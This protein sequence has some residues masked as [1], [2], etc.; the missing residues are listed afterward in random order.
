M[1]REPF[2]DEAVD[3][4]LKA[5]L[6]R[7]RFRTRDRLERPM[8]LVDR[9][10]LDPAFDDGALRGGEGRLVGVRRRHDLVLVRTNNALPELRGLNVA[11]HDRAHALAIGV[12]RLGFVEAEPGLPVRGVGAVARE[13]ILGENRADLLVEGNLGVRGV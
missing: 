2:R 9:T 6:R 13:T 11:R 10:F 1:G 12:G 5:C 3:G 4:V 7:R 8:P